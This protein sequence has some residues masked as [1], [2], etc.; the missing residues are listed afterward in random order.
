MVRIDS[1]R[2]SLLAIVPVLA[3]S[4]VAC[5]GNV[6]ETAAAG[7]QTATEQQNPSMTEQ[8]ADDPVNGVAEGREADDQG[9]AAAIAQDGVSAADESADEAG[10]EIGSRG[11]ALLSTRGASIANEVKRQTY[12][13]NKSTSYYSHTTYMNETTDTRRTDCSGFVGY[14]LNRVQPDAYAKIPHP[15]TYKPLANDWYNYL[16][17][18]YTTASTQSTP[19]WRKITKAMDLKPGDMVVWLQPDGNTDENTGHIMVVNGYPRAGRTGEVVV[20]II[21]STTAPHANDSRGSTM[22]G[23]GSGTIGLKVN[24][25]GQPIAYYWRGG[26]SYNAI[27][28]KI[29][30]GRL[31]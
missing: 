11:D 20:S 23:V 28:T 1:L 21:D 15:N 4:A 5:T 2:R 26:L 31:E 3:L 10:D 8:Q 9:Y 29:A 6:D 17:T 19:R 24:S 18:R 27:Q 14:A 16:S 25:L 30:L 12:E 22:T 7:E 13:L